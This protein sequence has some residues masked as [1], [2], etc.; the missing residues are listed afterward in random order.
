MRTGFME[1]AGLAALSLAGCTISGDDGE[2][3]RIE[4]FEQRIVLDMEGSS[5]PLPL[6]AM[7]VFLTEDDWPETFE[8]RGNGITL[9][10]AFPRNVRVDYEENWPVLIGKPIP[11][12]ARGG[13]ENKSSSLTIPAVG[14]FRVLGGSFTI[15]R[16][17][18]GYD[19]KTPLTGRI[20]LRVL[21][22]GGETQLRG[23]LAVKG[24]TW[25]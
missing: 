19:A 2:M 1:V 6:E 21:G 7:D 12:V 16:T 8:I 11:I 13:G 18:P 24:T 5:L 3:A 14:T 20:E 9:V 25:G 15:E 22:A 10:G 23:T 4:A 17:E